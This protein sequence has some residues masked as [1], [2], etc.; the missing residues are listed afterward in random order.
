M[1]ARQA[2]DPEERDFFRDLFLL[3]AKP[4]IYVVNVS[5]EQVGEESERM[6]QIRQI[7][8]KDGAPMVVICGKMEAEI[9]EL[10]PS[11][12]EEFLASYGLAESGLDRFIKAGYRALNLI[13]YL[14]AGPT[15]SRAW[16]ITNGMK[17]PQAAGV[18]HSD[19]ERGFIKAEVMSFDDLDRLGSE[20]AVKEAGLMKIEGK[21]YVVKE[22]DVMHFRFNV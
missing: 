8:G 17:A 15:E 18:I 2:I 3:T 1:K 13:T 11:E 20:A 22:G 9:A 19:F 16:T 21:D 5:E 7:A 14:T 4:L 6:A 12:K 10:D